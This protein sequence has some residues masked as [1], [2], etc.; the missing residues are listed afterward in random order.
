MKFDASH[1]FLNQEFADKNSVLEFVA[2]KAQELQIAGDQRS[3]FEGLL[4]REAEFSTG[5]VDGIAIPHC[6]SEALTHA[7]LVFIRLKQGIEWGSLDDQRV[8]TVLAMLVPAAQAEHVHLR[9]LAALAAQL[10]DRSFRQE[11]KE[12]TEVNEVVALINTQE[13]NV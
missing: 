6:I 12:C 3:V 8:D 11:L 1:V 13:E 4:R 5:M 7:G 10:T 9:M 2:C